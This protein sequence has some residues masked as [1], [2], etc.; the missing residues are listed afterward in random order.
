MLAPSGCEA[1][2]AGRVL[3]AA[4]IASHACRSL[5]DCLAA[6]GEGAGMVLVADEALHTADL[7]GIAA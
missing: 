4:D 5:A 7:R 2:I 6:P 3:G 1:F